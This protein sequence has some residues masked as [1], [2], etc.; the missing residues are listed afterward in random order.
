MRAASDSLVPCVLELG[1][2]DCAIIRADANLQQAL[3][4]LLRGVYQNCGQNCIGIERIIVHRDVYDKF[5][6]LMLE[7]VSKLRVG[8]PL[9]DS[10][11]DCGAMTMGMEVSY[12]TYMYVYPSLL[13]IYYLE[14]SRS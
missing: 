3:Q 2:K 8:A 6:E 4:L 10:D 12:L 11:V 9:D 7:Q 14:L 1:G 13:I 5:T